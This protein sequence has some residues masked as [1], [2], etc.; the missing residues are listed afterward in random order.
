MAVRKIYL[1]LDVLK[2]DIVKVVNKKTFRLDKPPK[3]CS[4]KC[5]DERYFYNIYVSGGLCKFF[6]SKKSYGIFIEDQCLE[7]E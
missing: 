7:K 1:I 3:V 2:G 4:I 5:S 6:T